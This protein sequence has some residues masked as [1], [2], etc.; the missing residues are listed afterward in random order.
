MGE[1]TDGVIE[2]VSKLQAKVKG[3]SGVDILTDTGAYKDTYTIIKEIAQVW[4]Q[5]NDIDR[6]ALLELLAGKNRSNAMAALLTNLEDLEGAYESAME[7]QGSAEAENEKYMNSIQG[8][9]DQFTNA[10]QVMWKDTLNSEAIKFFIDVAKVIVTLVDKIGLLETAIGGLFAYFTQIKPAISSRKVWKKVIG[11]DGSEYFEKVKIKA[12]E[13]VD[14]VGNASQDMA[15]KVAES[16]QEATEKVV[17]ASAQETA[18]KEASTAAT[19]EHAAANEVDKASTTEAAAAEQTR[20]AT[21]QQEATDQTAATSA[22]LENVAANE[23]D[24]K[25]TLEAAAAEQVRAGT[26]QA[27]AGAQAGATASVGVNAGAN[28][29]GDVVSGAASSGIFSKLFSKL[30]G[31]AASGAAGGLLSGIGSKAAALIPVVGKAILVM[32]AVNLVIKGVNKLIGAI[33]NKIHEAENLKKEVTALEKDFKQK[34]QESDSMLKT[35]TTSSDE[36]T[37][38]T[39]VD[40]FRKLAGGVDQYGNNISLT[41][42]QYNRYK[43]ICET[44][45]KI[46]PSLASGYDSVT[47]AVGNNI[48]I[49]EQLIDLQKVQARQDAREYTSDENIKKIAKN[50]INDYKDAREEYQRVLSGASLKEDARSIFDDV[51]KT[52]GG[53]YKDIVQGLTGNDNIT[54]I[55]TTQDTAARYLSQHLGELKDKLQDAYD[56]GK[57]LQIF[58]DNGA[59]KKTAKWIDKE[60]VAELLNQVNN[61]EAEYEGA[62]T[63]AQ[64]NL[65][66]K[67]KAL[68]DTLLQ[69]PASMQEYEGLSSNS[70]N[71][72]VQWIKNSKMFEIDDNFKAKDVLGM[73]T[74]IQSFIRDLAN[75]A[76]QY[77][78]KAGD[79]IK[80]LKTGDKIDASMILDQIVDI[81]PSKVD[82]SQYKEQVQKLIDMLWESLGTSGQAKFNND[83]GTFAVSLGFDFTT[84]DEDVK[85]NSELIAKRLGMDAEEIQKKVE[86]MP[87]SQVDAFVKINWNE[88]ETNSWE[89]VVNTIQKQATNIEAPSIDAYSTLADGV[90]KFNEVLTQ[91]SE[92]VADNT[93]VTQEYKDSITALGFSQEELN[94]V[95]D[96][97]NPLL[98]KNAALL[99]K[100]VIQKREEKRATV[101]AAKAQTQLQYR[102]TVKQLQQVVA[103]M[104]KEYKATGLV[105]NA[106]KKS[107]DVLR[108]QL[109]ALRQTQREYALLE[110]QLSGVTNA[111][112]NFEKAKSI[113]E[114]LTYG[115]SM[116]EM[117]NTINDGFKTGQV[118]TE[119]FQAAVKTL[120]PSSVYEDLDNFNDRMVAIHDYIDQNPLFADWFTIK[121]GEFSITQKNIQSFV[122][123]AQKAGAFTISDENGN[124]DLGEGVE[125]IDD[126]VNK[127]NEAQ[128]GIGVT[129]EAVVA[130]L[131]EF[132]KYD[133]TWSDIL[134][135]LTTN[136]FDKEINKATSD[137]EKAVAAQD[138]YIRSG[139]SLDGEEWKTICKN[140]EAAEA[141]LNKANAAAQNNA[142]QYNALETIYNSATGKLKL[143]QEQAD[144]LVKSLNLVDQNGELIKINVEDGQ[145]KLTTEQAELL[146][147]KLKGLQ[148]PTIVSVQFDFDTLSKQLEVAKKYINGDELSEEDKTVLFN[149][150]INVDKITSEQL[151]AKI[152]ALPDDQKQV[153][154]DAGINFDGLSKEE[155]QQ[156]IDEMPE[157][158][159]KVLLD[160]GIK[161]DAM[162]EE[163]LKTACNN[164]ITTVEPQLKSISL[165]YGI[166]KTSEEQQ[167]GT[168]EKLKDWEVNGIHFTAYA[169]M[170]EGSKNKANEEKEELGEDENPTVYPI[171]DPTSYTNA[172]TKLDNLEKDRTSTVYVNTVETGSNSTNTSSGGYS[173]IRRGR[174][175][176]TA[177]AHGNWGAESTDTSL[178][179][180]LGPELRV[181]GNRWDMLGENGAEF[182]DVKKGDII[183]NHKQT[184]S[185][186][187]NGYINSRGKAY[188]SG[189]SYGI[190]NIFDKLKLNKLAKYAEEMCKQYEELVNGNVDLRKRPHLSPSYEHDLAM[191]GGYNSFIGSDG[192]IYASTSAE[193]VTIGDKNKYT[194]DITPV[195]ENGDVLTSDALADY[196]D[197]LVTDGSTQDLLDSDKYNLVIRAVPG[198]Y[199]EKDWVGFEDEL[200]EYKDGYLNTIMEMFNLGGEKAVESSGFS[201]VGLANVTKDLQDNG[202]YTGKEVASAIDDTSDG[203]RKLDNLIDQYVTDVLNAKSLADDIG[204]D[205]SQTKY[206]NVDTNDRQKLYWDEESIDKYSDAM[207]SWGMK[208]DDLVGTYSTL[209][210]S[211][212]E[213]DGE[214]IAFTPILQTDDGPQLLDSNTVDKYIWG[215][216]D[217]AKQNDGKWTSDELFQLDTKGL[218]VDGVV[219]K[220]LLEGIGQDADK[221]AKLLH[222]VGDTGS[223]ANLEGEIESTS[224]ELVVTGENVSDVQAKLDKLN[225]TSISDKTFTVTTDYRTIGSGTERTI[226]TPGA[227]GRLTIYAD[228]TA[229]ASGNWGLEKSEHNSLV[230]ELGTETV[231]DPHTG[232]YYT[233]GDHGAELVDLPKDAI[234]FNHLQTKELFKNGHINSRGKLTGGAYAE[235][236]AHYGLFT[237]YTD[238]N[239]VFKNGSSEWVNAWDDTMRDLSDAAD[240]LSSASDGISDAADDFEEVFDWFEI[241]LEEI[242]N[243]ISLMTAQLENAIGAG[244]KKNIYS[245]ILDTEYFKVKELNDGI[246]LY[247][248]YANKLL[249]KVPAQYQ[250]MAKNGAVAITDFLGEANQEVVESINNY[251]EWAKKVTD[252]NQQLE[253]TKTK[254]SDTHVEIQNMLKDEYDNRI[255]LITSVNDRIQGTIDLLDE[256]G[257]RSSAVMYEEMIKNSTKQ[258]SELQNKR[259]EMQRALDEAVSSGDVEK[260]SS[261]WYEMVNAIN[262]VDG[263]INDC[264]IDLEGFQN[265]I[266]QLH[267]DNFEKFIDAIDNVGNE[268]SNLGDLIDEEDIVD[269]VGNW[270]DKGVTAL[271]LYAQEMERAKYRA[272]QYG[273]EIEYLNQEYAA[274]KYSE[275]EYLEKLQE[276]RDGQ[277][278]SIKSYESAKKSIID[279]NKTRIEAV[280][281]GIQKEIDAYSELIDKKK[282][283]LSL[284]KDAH[285]FQKQ[286]TEKQKEI[287]DIQK[288]LA[289]MSGDNSASAIAQKKKLQAELA[290]AQEELDEIYYDHSV[291]KQQEALDKSLENYQDEKDTEME[292]LDESLKNEEQIIADSYA[293][294]AANTES[295]AQ[296]L[297]DI[298]SQYGITLSDSVTKP[299]LDGANAIGTYQEQLDTSM[300]SF[301]QQLETLKKMYSDLQAQADSTGKSM[302]DAINSNK[303]KTE[304]ST[305]TPPAPSQPS[306]PSTPSAPY[307]GA[308]VTVKRSA[309]HFSRDGGN[310]TRMQSWVPGSDFTVYQVSGSDV[311][312]GRNGGYT[313]WV[314]LSDLEGYASG[315]KGVSKDQLAMLDELGDELVL[316]AGKNGRLEFLT[317]GTSVIPSDITENLM[318][319]GSLDPRQV[320]D[321]NR[322]SIGAPHIVNNSMEINMQIAEVVHI[323]HADNSSIPDIT[324]AVQNQIDAYM[325]KVNSSLRRYT[326]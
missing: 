112:E 140:V 105:A 64:T 81:N 98:V 272:E 154:L 191:G 82:Y 65:E 208:A 259:A 217:E 264:R 209:L 51:Y 265:S 39:L 176:G 28:A 16:Q 182:T 4:D 30:G 78:V 258:L 59:G 319:L 101:Q 253:E 24:T 246:K 20:A 281:D 318:K 92:I 46:N 13:T 10:V 293:T 58:L 9:I 190:G 167:D 47:K 239:E 54:D 128:D 224:S 290:A 292:K 323:D 320:L 35:L 147:A 99:R 117:L 172:E 129:K 287:A 193:T 107:V 83:K 245:Q 70:Q 309:T 285:D 194:I 221:T 186:L 288:K 109:T 283:E 152:N 138:E 247:S 307:N 315:T 55:I 276:L 22:T 237:G 17:E 177:H 56:K 297:S 204:T 132:S 220:N 106:T 273:K 159:K 179:G 189:T 291:E 88:V 210:S 25:S 244:A 19:V 306:A 104:G 139:K 240:S 308:T 162:S 228:G 155:I 326:R 61:A 170:D 229:N 284:Q 150:G 305:Y 67:K 213:F 261:Q 243:N 184:Q 38:A 63:A 156:K 50:A 37:Y 118:G 314:K 251:R 324:K 157:D 197:G 279:L 33:S 242:E 231:V 75:N 143:T 149:A 44:I 181:R 110:I 62:L 144:A 267:W 301:T 278:D 146:N 174:F 36:K 263:E 322:P 52:I 222:Y 166:T 141:A 280:K 250:E 302:I 183:F 282:E 214:D 5:M 53:G 96:E 121:D 207:D 165:T 43:E 135:D 260:E 142:K 192:E 196:I 275:D 234:I 119:A 68:I 303:T 313:G 133:A 230:G 248:D 14:A 188:A 215:L 169:K 115:D 79:N 66:Q 198:E 3:L 255:S 49:L 211:V 123:D 269:E 238:Y 289:V 136:K 60:Q 256:E 130:M 93:N 173:T 91:T 34:K 57:G 180:E 1:E 95:F 122:D 212:G 171:V 262:D 300:S 86:D 233:V 74:S 148:E 2:S 41:N 161:V 241:L 27:E 310:G 185:L 199:D 252:L 94:D 71:F 18:A 126:F 87:A 216:I 23:A 21:S 80:G 195:L 257:K 266:N 286:V 312:I 134:S 232:R 6:A 103:A 236:N 12:K 202:S 76:Y 219:V 200:S 97:S 151:Q 32:G 73:K 72:I 125:T 298:A 249:A 178:V 175:D 102:N 42:E 201:S 304:S 205:L 225:A 223:I 317:K 158:Q 69:I 120:V 108:S 48:S 160:A 277:W 77:T 271:G 145:V 8:K 311:L 45:C 164:L 11:E 227:S 218:E 168:I 15:Q 296:T 295:I 137:L 321:N 124:F 268:I 131:T 7:A 111:Y 294:I 116:I 163:E 226:H 31:K 274:G 316:H 90:S 84:K 187:E 113:D 114:K 325:S 203:M 235:G 89:D 153:L 270:T 254:I 29:I 100:L 26:S 40:E 127:I 299:W 206:G 85:K